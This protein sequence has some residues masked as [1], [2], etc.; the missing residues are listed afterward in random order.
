[1]SRTSHKQQNL[2]TLHS[3]SES[4]CLYDVGLYARLSSEDNGKDSDSIESQIELM[5]KYIAEN[6]TMKKAAAFIDNGYTGTNF[7]R[8]GFQQMIDAARAGAINC[9]VVKDLSRLGRNYLETGSFLER[10]FPFLGV[11]VI[12]LNDNYD[13]ASLSNN[14]E[15][16]ASLS[17]IINDFYAKDISRKVFSALA[18]KMANGEYIGAWEKYGYLKDPENK[19]RLI[20]NPETAPVV[21]QIFQW[22]STGMSYMGINK[23]LNEMG[24]LSPGQYK[25]ERGIVTNNNQKPRKILW[26][27]HIISDILKDITYIG[28]MAQRKTTQNLC[29]GVPF[30]RVDERDWVIANNTH[31][32]IITQE[33]FDKVQEV[34]RSSAATAKSNYGKYDYLPKAKNIYGAKLVCADC[35]AQMKLQRSISR[36]KDKAYFTYICP[37][38]AEH[39]QAGCLKK[40]MRKADLDNAVFQ[41]IRA[42]MDT[43]FEYATVI[44]KLLAKKQA[45]KSNASQKQAK[46]SLSLKVRNLRSQISNLYIDFK[47][48]LLNDEEYLMQ[49]EKYSEKL[50]E[51]ERALN[52]FVEDE[53]ET[54]EQ[55]VGMK[56]WAAISKK[57]ANAAELSEELLTACVKQIK[58]HSDDYLE[59]EFNYMQEFGELLETAERLRKDVA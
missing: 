57:F 32:P 56:R 22:R 42:Q 13:S 12:A 36:K 37:T 15:L 26:N 10:I 43:F 25:A 2:P 17:N 47:D 29:S 33:L 31:E 51:A 27:K 52:T 19:N 4:A 30:T 16:A 38:Y 39:G 55:L 9:I 6:P 53:S 46:A 3:I 50:A 28:H 41:A 23:Q 20:V 59:I 21:Q 40:R 7:E 49:K 8:P 14:S 54:E 35:G 45:V 34:N 5:E 1:M 24:I 11:R 58:F 48:G 18:V 44:K